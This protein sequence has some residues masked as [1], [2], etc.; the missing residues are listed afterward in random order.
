MSRNTS[1]YEYH[2]PS[3]AIAQTP[4]EP[5]DSARLLLADDLTDRTFSELPELLDPG[6]LVVV[7]ETRVRAGRLRGHR[8]HGGTVE[9]LLLERRSDDTW[10]ALMRPARK[11]RAGQDLHFGEISARVMTEPVDGRVTL[12]LEVPGDIEHSIERDGEVPLP[13]YITR[14]LEDPDRYQT[15]Y[16][17]VTGSAAAP[18]AGLHF[19]PAVL[20]RLEKRGIRLARVELRVGIGT[21]RPITTPEVDRHRMHPEWSS[22]PAATVAAVAEARRRGGAVVA[23][24]TTVVRALEWRASGGDLTAGSGYTDLFI[25]P[26]HRFRVVD[27]LLTNFHAPRSSL[28]VMVAAFMGPRWRATYRTALERGYRFLSFGD[29]MLASRSED[30]VS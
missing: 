28:V 10:E 23:I 26:G 1:E 9:A 4:A 27:R 5:R 3:A 13:P 11:L 25:R 20:D 19:T 7:N 2:L 17:S 29:A 15:V 8:S 30:V 22:V 16:A 6:D 18:T 12:R 21:F 24:G 14:P